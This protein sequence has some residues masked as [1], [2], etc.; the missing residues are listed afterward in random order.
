M[1]SR[2]IYPPPGAWRT[3]ELRAHQQVFPEGQLVAVDRPTGRTVGLAASLVVSSERWPPE[4]SWDAVTG[5]GLFGTHDPEGGDIL[6]GAGVAVHPEARGR[7][8]ARRLYAARQALLERMGLDRI[9]A[10]ARIS[11]YGAVA[12]RMSAEAYVDEVV[13]GRRRDPALSFQLRMGFQV[14]AVAAAYLPLDQASRG[15]AAVVEWTPSGAG[16]KG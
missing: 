11:G 6:Y 13:R 14:V 2:Q 1:L 12:E 7:G 16:E 3:D 10:G 5:G 9:R 4:A 8:V 15:Y